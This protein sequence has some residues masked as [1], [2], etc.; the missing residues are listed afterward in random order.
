[1]KGVLYRKDGKGA[2]ARSEL[3]E[4]M[5]APLINAPARSHFAL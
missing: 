2:V 4:T 5:L 3:F 1:M